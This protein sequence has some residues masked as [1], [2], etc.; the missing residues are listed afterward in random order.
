MNSYAIDLAMRGYCVAYYENPSS[1]EAQE[2]NLHSNGP[3]NHIVADTR[4]AFYNGF[5]SS[6]AADIYI[7]HNAAQ[8][9]VDTTKIFASG[10]SFGAFCSLMLA[11]A[12]PGRNFTDTIFNWQGGYNAKSIY[13][14]PFLKNIHYVIPI[15]GGLPKDDTTFANNSHM[16]NFI[17]GEENN[18]SILFLHG[19]TDNLVSFYLTKFGEADTSS[20]YLW[21][22][23]PLALINNIAK[24]NAAIPSKLFINCRSG[25]PFKTSVCGYSNPYCLPQWQWQYLPEPMGDLS[26]TNSYYQDSTRDTLLHYFA[27]N[28]TQQLDIGLI[29][30]DFLQPVIL[31]TTSL[32]TDHLY[33]LQPRDSFTYANPSGHYILRTTDCEGHAVVVTSDKPHDLQ[34]S[35]FKMY[36]NPG[37]NIIT[38]EANE[39]IEKISVYS[40][41]GALIKNID[42]KNLQEQVDVTSLPSGEYIC[43]IQL[44]GQ[45]LTQKLSIIR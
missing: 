9:S 41:L 39:A 40:M 37:N 31:N 25:H 23:G 3:F 29:M 14:D 13:D 8:L 24:Y 6:V 1:A 35:T 4:N 15:G 20:T 11:T 32:F 26:N 7:K 17:D 33:F 2:M 27:Y 42:C 30:G 34:R 12:D 21:G 18:L 10:F 16:G 28:M 44:N 45:A 38:F 22:E 43:I 19:R 36:P 5:Q